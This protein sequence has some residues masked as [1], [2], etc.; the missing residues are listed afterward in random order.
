MNIKE[1]ENQLAFNLRFEIV[2]IVFV[3]L[4][5]VGFVEYRLWLVS[6]IKE[7]VMSI[8][9]NIPTIK[10]DNLKILRSSIKSVF[11]SNLP[12]VRLEP[13]D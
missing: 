3:W 1:Q 2:L 7:P 13:F 4:F 5:V 8:M 9:N 11:V 12:T 6:S 10:Q